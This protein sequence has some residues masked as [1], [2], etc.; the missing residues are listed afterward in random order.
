MTPATTEIVAIPPSHEA[1]RR[2]AGPPDAGVGQCRMGRLRAPDAARV[3]ARARRAQAGAARRQADRARARRRSGAHRRGMQGRAVVA[4][5]ERGQPWTTRDARRATSRAGATSRAEI[6]FVIG[7][8]DGLAPSIKRDAPAVVALS[9][10]TLPHGLCRVLRRRAALSRREPARRAP[11]PS[12]MSG[13]RR[14]GGEAKARRARLRAMCAADPAAHRAS[15]TVRRPRCERR[16]T[17]ESACHLPRLAKSTPARAPAPA[18]RRLRRASAAGSGRTAARR[19][20]GR[21]RRR[22]G[23]PLRRADRAYQGGDRRRADAQRRGLPPRPVLGADTEVVLDGTIFGKPRDAGRCGAD[24]RA[25][26]GTHASGVDCRRGLLER[27][28]DG[29]DRHVGRHVPPLDARRDQPLCR[30]RRVGRQGGRLRDPGPG[31]G[32][33]RA[34]SKAAIPA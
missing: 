11:V 1:P 23:A 34:G 15:G 24:A 12:R 17:H 5:D 33:H 25:P 2:R 3:R 13:T 26:L 6:A 27:R 8:A 32:L 30:D 9:A 18:R 4:L 28:G 10:L 21:A 19:R 20:R 16:I 14:E 29:G 31:R 22:T 7:S